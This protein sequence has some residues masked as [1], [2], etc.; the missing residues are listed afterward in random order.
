MKRAI[1]KDKLQCALNIAKNESKNRKL[2]DHVTIMVRNGMV[3]LV[4]TDGFVLANYSLWPAVG[5]DWPAVG[6][7]PF[8]V[9]SQ[10]LSDALSRGDEYFREVLPSLK[11]DEPYLTESMVQSLLPKPTDFSFVF[12]VETKRLIDWCKLAKAMV[13]GKSLPQLI[14]AA[15]AEKFAIMALLRG[16]YTIGEEEGAPVLLWEDDHR[17]YRVQN[18]DMMAAPVLFAFRPEKLLKALAIDCRFSRIFVPDSNGK[19]LTVALT[20]YIDEQF[21]TEAGAFVA[22]NFACVARSSTSVTVD[23]WQA[24]REKIKL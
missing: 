22:T 7:E 8:L 6:G 21:F 19:S 4:P 10:S 24:L 5:G 12:V 20:N 11:C 3:S 16:E 17:Y 15:D 14:I 2:Q 23:T 9:S 1:Y 18:H 13:T